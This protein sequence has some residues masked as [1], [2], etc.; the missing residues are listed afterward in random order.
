[1]KNPENSENKSN[2]ILTD[3]SPVN[4]NNSSNYKIFEENVTSFDS[5]MLD[6]SDNFS[7]GNKVNQIA[8]ESKLNKEKNIKKIL[9]MNIINFPIDKTDRFSCK[10]NSKKNINIKNKN[11]KNNIVKLN[12]SSS[13]IE[14]NYIQNQLDSQDNSTIKATTDRLNNSSLYKIHTNKISSSNSLK[15][16][17]T[18]FNSILNIDLNL[19]KK[20]NSKYI[21]EIKE[22]HSCKNLKNI[23]LLNPNI[24]DFKTN[25][26]KNDKLNNINFCANNINNNVNNLTISTDIVKNLTL[27]NQNNLQENNFEKNQILNNNV[28]SNKNIIIIR[29]SK[30][31]NENNLG[32]IT[33]KLTINLENTERLNKEAESLSLTATEEYFELINFNNKDNIS[34]IT[35][36]SR[37]LFKHDLASLY[38]PL[39]SNILS[40]GGKTDAITRKYSVENNLWSTVREIKVERSDFIALMYKEKRI[41]LLGGKSL[42]YN[43]IE[44]VSDTID[45]LST[46]DQNLVRLDFKLKFPRCNFGAVYFEYKLYVAGG[47][48]GRET[49]NNF[50]YFDKKSKKW[51]ELQKMNNKKKEFSMIL[52][53][54]NN[55]YCVGGSDERE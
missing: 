52:C 37:S 48:N 32:N 24:D 19:L 31:N 30:H 38:N 12:N 16:Q 54:D 29:A 17:K 21:S 47:Y 43:G 35:D 41:L 7:K 15:D 2:D 27:S 28:N 55:I 20:N 42:N 51:V 34:K 3:I 14:I 5:N 44:Q 36:N 6:A 13:V 25:I 1:M 11:I 50:E 49:I 53:S 9:D 4:P 45:L 40:L 8:Q 10:I 22:K 18:K 26:V 39:N 23:D 46:D 33:D